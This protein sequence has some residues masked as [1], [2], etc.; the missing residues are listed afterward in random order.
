LAAGSSPPF[1]L[2]YRPR[3]TDL[4]TAHQQGPTR[5][6]RGFR[7]TSRPALVGMDGIHRQG[8]VNRANPEID[9]LGIMQLR[10]SF[11]QAT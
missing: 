9:Y 5:F 1:Y 2:G 3:H 6:E 10:I 8:Q 4:F 7:L 11:K